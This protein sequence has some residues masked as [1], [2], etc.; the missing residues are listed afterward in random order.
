MNFNIHSLLFF[1]EL[2]SISNITPPLTIPISLGPTDRCQKI[3]VFPLL[4]FPSVAY[5]TI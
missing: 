3:M 4:L 5:M 2:V 1:L